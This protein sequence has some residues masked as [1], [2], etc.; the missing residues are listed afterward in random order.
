MAE[1]QWKHWSPSERTRWK[2]AYAW[3]WR[4]DA[5][6]ETANKKEME[7]DKNSEEQ[8]S[9]RQSQLQIF[10]RTPETYIAWTW[11]FILV[12]QT[13]ISPLLQ[14]Q[15]KLLCKYTPCSTEDCWVTGLRK[16][17]KMVS[18][19]LPRTV[20]NSYQ[21]SLCEALFLLLSYPDK[22]MP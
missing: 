21:N 7:G 3:M 13:A 8:Y 20:K 22:T 2:S 19:E 1:D 18:C 14:K 4:Q 17:D 12:C 15:K 5:D 6:S 11:H 9:L 16:K 10:I